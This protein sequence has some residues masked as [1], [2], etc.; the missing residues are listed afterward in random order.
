M[1]SVYCHNV[2]GGIFVY[3]HNTGVF[4]FSLPCG[5]IFVYCHNTGLD[6]TVRKY[7]FR[8]SFVDCAPFLLA[9]VQKAK[10]HHART[11]Q[12]ARAATGSGVYISNRL[13]GFNCRTTCV[14]HTLQKVAEQR[15]RS[16][17][18]DETVAIWLR[19]VVEV[20]NKCKPLFSQ[21]LNQ[22]SQCLCVR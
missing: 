16:K 4:F 15:I 5:G 10:Y 1:E 14:W 12:A 3:C 19:R 18:A 11:L 20:L 21:L 22:T 6:Q 2:T 8:R 17:G 7:N 9:Q 13:M